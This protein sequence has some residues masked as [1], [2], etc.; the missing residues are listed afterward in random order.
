MANLKREPLE[1]IVVFLPK[2]IKEKITA[3]AQALKISRSALASIL[4]RNQLREDNES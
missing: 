2:E 3:L 4:I 1:Q